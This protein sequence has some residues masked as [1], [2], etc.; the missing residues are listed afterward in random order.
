MNLDKKV[1]EKEQHKPILGSLYLHEPGAVEV[2][3]GGTFTW[4]SI[5]C[6]P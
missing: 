3:L 4:T 6:G 2:F 1:R 5:I